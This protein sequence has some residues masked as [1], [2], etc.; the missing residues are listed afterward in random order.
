IFRCENVTVNSD[1]RIKTVQAD[2]VDG[3]TLR[4]SNRA[5]F[6]S[7]IWAGC[8]NVEVSVAGDDTFD[9]ETL[10][11]GFT[12]LS[13][14]YENLVFERSQFKIHFVR[15]HLFNDELIRLP[16]GFPTTRRERDEFE[17]KQ[18]EKIQ[19]IAKR[20]GIRIHAREDAPKKGARN[21]P[22]DCGSG[23]KFKKCCG[24]N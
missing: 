8:Q 12:E 19:A 21:A 10:T 20:A 6:H 13:Q 17:R 18:E 22:C 9:A 16:N 15:K 23:R 7:V 2:L 3:L 4:F 5:H 11:T 1:V 24:A 14:E